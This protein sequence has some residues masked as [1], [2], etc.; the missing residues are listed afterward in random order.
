MLNGMACA[1]SGAETSAQKAA[2]VNTIRDDR[3]MG[4]ASVESGNSLR[5]KSRLAEADEQDESDRI[6]GP[7]PVAFEARMLSG[8]RATPVG[9]LRGVV[10]MVGVG[11][12]LPLT[13]RTIRRW[14]AARRRP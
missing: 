7:Y 14:N 13:V 2:Q 10:R 12:D 5:S 8:P 3:D 4:P 1:L 6:F 11:Q 9:V